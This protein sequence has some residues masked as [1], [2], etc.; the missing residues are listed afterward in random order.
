MNCLQYHKPPH[1]SRDKKWTSIQANIH[2]LYII[3]F[4]NTILFNVII[5]SFSI[6]DFGF[7]YQHAGQHAKPTPSHPPSPD[8]TDMGMYYDSITTLYQYPSRLN[9]NLLT[10]DIESAG[11][12]VSLIAAILR[13]KKGRKIRKRRSKQ[14]VLLYRRYRPYGEHVEQYCLTRLLQEVPVTR[15]TFA[16]LKSTGSYLEECIARKFSIKK[17]KQSP[18]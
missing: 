11:I 15:D 9:L 13:D 10:D 1:Y 2:D 8:D 16:T 17:K 4:F 3:Q 18:S 6:D 12:A 14:A 5:E 7:D